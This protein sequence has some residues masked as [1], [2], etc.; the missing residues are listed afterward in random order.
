MENNATVTPDNSTGG[1][2]PIQVLANDNFLPERSRQ[3]ASALLTN[4]H[5]VCN[6]QGMRPED[7]RK[8][9]DKV[10]QVCRRLPHF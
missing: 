10:D 2:T 9:L 8:F 5:L 7:Q 4:K 6:L 3:Q 1:G